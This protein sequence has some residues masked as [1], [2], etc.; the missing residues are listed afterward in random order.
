MTQR[1]LL[2]LIV[3]CLVGLSTLA[4][5]ADD[6]RPPAVDSCAASYP[7]RLAD[8]KHAL[9]EWMAFMAEF[10]KVKPKIEWFEAHCRF[11]EQL[12]IVVRKID[13]PNAFVCNTSKGRPK[14]LTSE[15][16]MQYSTLPSVGAYQN[17]GGENA[18]CMERDETARMSLFVPTGD[19]LASAGARLLL[20][21]FN[22]DGP[23]CV[24]AR[25]AVAAAHAKK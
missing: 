14:D 10:Q 9:S 7:E 16:V 11:L 20:S 18:A 24:E 23:D 8:A 2:R 6:R 13:D 3:V 17:F 1:L 15:L 21:C 12:E 5:Y 22:D 4:A 25:A 19:D